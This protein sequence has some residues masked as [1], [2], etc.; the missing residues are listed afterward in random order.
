MN[1]NLAKQVRKSSVSD[2]ANRDI[3]DPT[4][5]RREKV[6]GDPDLRTVIGIEE[7]TLKSRKAK[8]MQEKLLKSAA[9][10]FSRK[11]YTATCIAV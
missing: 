5:P 9:I 1:S 3:G 4:Q 7:V 2:N 11:G 6:A 8:R 10:V